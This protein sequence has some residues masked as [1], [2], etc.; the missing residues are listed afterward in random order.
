M[1]EVCGG[2]RLSVPCP[3][4]EDAYGSDVAKCLVMGKGCVKAHQVL[5]KPVMRNKAVRKPDF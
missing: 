1:G 4:S 2:C 3:A 5:E